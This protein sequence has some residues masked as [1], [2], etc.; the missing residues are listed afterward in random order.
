MRDVNLPVFCNCSTR[1]NQKVSMVQTSCRI[2]RELA[3]LAW[4]DA[5]DA[6]I[7]DCGRSYSWIEDDCFKRIK[8]HVRDCCWSHASAVPNGWRIG[9]SAWHYW[10]QAEAGFVQPWCC[11]GT[12]LVL[13]WYYPGAILVL[14]W[15]YSRAI[16]VLPP[17]LPKAKAGW[18][19]TEA[20]CYRTNETSETSCFGNTPGAFMSFRIFSLCLAPAK[21]R[22][23]SQQS[24][25]NLFIFKL[26]AMTG[27]SIFLLDAGRLWL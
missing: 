26:N 15:Y 25:E 13:S 27:R 9:G 17:C 8:T 19:G 10:Y 23:R 4:F 1:L 6:L 20:D 18:N 16:P 7:D 12:I 5:F 2:W 11:W 24:G 21:H 14:H 3:Y 22:D